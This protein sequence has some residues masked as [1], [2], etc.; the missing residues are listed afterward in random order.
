MERTSS[1][2]LSRLQ[3][4]KGRDVGE[5]VAES[6]NGYNRKGILFQPHHPRTFLRGGATQQQTAADSIAKACLVTVAEMSAPF[7]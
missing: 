2:K 4:F 3:A 1:L 6:T 5:K 7:P